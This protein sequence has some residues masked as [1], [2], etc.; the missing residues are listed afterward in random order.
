M[1]RQGIPLF[2]AVAIACG[3]GEQ[4]TSGAEAGADL[5]GEEVVVET[6][7]AEEA[8]VAPEIA[9]TADAEAA[10]ASS[11]AWEAE[12]TA[13]GAAEAPAPEASE[14]AAEDLPETEESG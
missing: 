10:E 2:V 3:G 1:I 8:D 9:E 14:E 13:E 6:P 5:T 7:V 12:E 11:E 4:T